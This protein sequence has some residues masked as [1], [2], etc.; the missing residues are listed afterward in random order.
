MRASFVLFVFLLVVGTAVPVHA[1][2]RSQVASHTQPGPAQLFDTEA[3]SFTL[4]KLFDPQHFRMGHSYEMSVGS[5]GGQSSSMGMYTNSLMWQFGPQL[6]A[7]VDIGVAHQFFG[8]Q[9]L[10][11]DSQAAQVFLRNAEINYRPSENTQIHFSFRQSPYGNYMHPH[12]YG[13]SP[14]GMRGAHPF[15]VY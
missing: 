1:Q 2:M 7:R 13:Y 11:A 5:Y 8:P 6:D 4:N 3:P 15:G 12:G 10:G 14:Y 9:Q